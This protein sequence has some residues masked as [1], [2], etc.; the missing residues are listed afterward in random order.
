M[1]NPK[2]QSAK[3]QRKAKQTISGRTKNKYQ[4]TSGIEAVIA[5]FVFLWVLA[6]G[7]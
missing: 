5:R 3:F 6:F 4:V 2:G 1:E 7:N